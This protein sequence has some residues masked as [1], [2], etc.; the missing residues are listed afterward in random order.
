MLARQRE[1]QEIIQERSNELEKLVKKYSA[2]MLCWKQIRITLMQE[3][4][5]LQKLRDE[6]VELKDSQ[7]IERQR[8]LKL[9]RE[10][11]E[12]LK[13][14]NKEFKQ[15]SNISILRLKRK[16]EELKRQKQKLN[17]NLKKKDE[18]QKKSITH[19]WCSETTP[20]LPDASRKYS[21]LRLSEISLRKWYQCSSNRRGI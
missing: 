11:H 2:A 6:I 14:K 5:S 1:G 15:D 16:Y 4:N 20:R 9:Q 13:R 3:L 21:K 10:E 19:E 7:E 18:I 17:S 12:Y 8:E